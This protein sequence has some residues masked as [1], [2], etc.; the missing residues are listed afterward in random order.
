MGSCKS[1]LLLCLMIICICSCTENVFFEQSDEEVQIVVSS[2]IMPNNLLSCFICQTTTPLSTVPVVDNASVAVYNDATNELIAEL[3]YIDNGWYKAKTKPKEGIIYRLE[4]SI[5][6][7]ELI[8]ATT[9]IPPKGKAGNF[10]LKYRATIDKMLVEPTESDLVHTLSFSVFDSG[11]D[12]H[13]Y[14]VVINAGLFLYAS[15]YDPLGHISYIRVDSLKEQLDNNN[16]AGDRASLQIRLDTLCQYSNLYTFYCLDAIINTENIIKNHMEPASLIFSNTT[17]MGQ[18]KKV[19][20]DLQY[21]IGSY[22]SPSNFR[23]GYCFILRSLSPEMFDYLQ[24]VRK[25]QQAV[26][27]KYLDSDFF[28][29]NFNIANT[30]VEI[31]SNINNGVGI[32][33]GYNASNYIIC[34]IGEDHWWQPYIK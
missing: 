6:G 22:N 34:P 29:G 31:I 7:Y 4:V 11:L 10:N 12:D 3:N 23:G 9:Q 8:T 15:Y 2:F 18:E 19:F 20:T 16:F 13:Y 24:S 27:E 17:F 30:Q 1:L 14:E 5:K 21:S 28:E 33:A 32:F 26:N 25:Q